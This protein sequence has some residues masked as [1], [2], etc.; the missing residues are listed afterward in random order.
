MPFIVYRSVFIL[1]C[2]RALHTY[3]L[4]H[5]RSPRA[6]VQSCNCATCSYSG[7]RAKGLSCIFLLSSEYSRLEGSRYHLLSPDF[8]EIESSDMDPAAGGEIAVSD[9][10]EQAFDGISIS[11]LVMTAIVVA[12]RLWNSWKG[13]KQFFADDCEL[14]SFF[15]MLV[16]FRLAHDPIQTRFISHCLP[17]S[18][19]RF[20]PVQIP[21]KYEFSRASKYFQ[22]PRTDRHLLQRSS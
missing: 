5:H 22:E 7:R 18:D 2:V 8:N 13:G 12:V 9:I 11:L 19:S 14:S 1:A 6:T 15:S 16:P 3:I 21:V 10:S 17:L 4:P 20:R